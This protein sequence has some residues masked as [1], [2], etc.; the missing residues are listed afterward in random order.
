[1]FHFNTIPM[2]TPNLPSLLKPVL[3]LCE[4]LHLFTCSSDSRLCLLWSVM[5]NHALNTCRQVLMREAVLNSLITTHLPRLWFLTPPFPLHHL[6]TK[7]SFSFSHC[8]YHF[9]I[10]T[11]MSILTNFIITLIIYNKL[12]TYV[13]ILHMHYNHRHYLW[14]CHHHSHHHLHH[15]TICP[16]SPIISSAITSLRNP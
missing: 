9:I 6:L 2:T 12:Y 1:M 4:I 7:H 15:C 16:P 10:L 11:G 13:Y 5:A 14:P 8:L 3:D